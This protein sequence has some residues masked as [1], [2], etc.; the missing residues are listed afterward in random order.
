MNTK[1]VI[2]IVVVVI[3]IVLLI[4]YYFLT[5]KPQIFVA[6]GT[7]TATLTEYNPSQTVTTGIFSGNSANISI[8]AS[9]S[10]NYVVAFQGVSHSFSSKTT[11]T[12]KPIDSNTIN[13]LYISG[14]G[15]TY[16]LTINFITYS[17]SVIVNGHVLTN[18]NPRTT[19]YNVTTLNITINSAPNQKY[20]VTYEIICTPKYLNIVPPI[21]SRTTVTTNSAGSISFTRSAPNNSNCSQTETIVTTYGPGMTVAYTITVINQSNTL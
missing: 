4:A 17:V 18:S 21:A 8:S 2:A 6:I 11:F 7:K 12:S 9:Q 20:T 10:G 1:I 5:R 16:S 19:L 3:A 15:E 14:F 13:T